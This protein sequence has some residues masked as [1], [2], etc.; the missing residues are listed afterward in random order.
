MNTQSGDWRSS[1]PSIEKHM[2]GKTDWVLIR[3]YYNAQISHTGE[4]PMSYSQDFPLYHDVNEAFGDEA[5][6]FAYDLEIK[7]RRSTQYAPAFEVAI[8]SIIGGTTKRLTLS[9]FECSNTDVTPSSD[10]G[11]DIRI[12]LSVGVNNGWETTY[13]MT[14]TAKSNGSL[15]NLCS[16]GHH[17]YARVYFRTYDGSTP[18]L[19][20]FS[21]TARCNAST[22]RVPCTVYYY[23]QSS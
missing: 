16:E 10:S 20:I 2:A 7:V 14:F 11:Y 15:Y 17:M 6:G 1:I 13:T 22:T 23:P 3:P 12:P 18:T 21:V 8:W 5:E 19:T 9:N 4:A